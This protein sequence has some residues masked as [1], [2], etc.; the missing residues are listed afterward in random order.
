MEDTQVLW[1]QHCLRKRR[2]NVKT[3]GIT[4]SFGNVD[5]PYLARIAEEVNPTTKW[6]IYYYSPKDKNRLKDVFGI[7]GISRK[8][9]TYFLPSGMF[10][11]D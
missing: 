1:G 2:K 10:W 6:I 8:F 7:L 3:G 5:A 11:D 9:E 4:L